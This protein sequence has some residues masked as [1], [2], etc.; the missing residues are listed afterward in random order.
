MATSQTCPG[1]GG[2]AGGGEVAGSNA[3]ECST[4]TGTTLSSM[5]TGESRAA[6]RSLDKVPI[7][8]T[9]GYR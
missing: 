5:I 2:I 9:A 8:G 7:P 4:T 1:F 3:G 6:G